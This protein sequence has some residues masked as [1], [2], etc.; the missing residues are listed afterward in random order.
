MR[1]RPLQALALLPAL[2]LAG[3][4]GAGTTV[5]GGNNAAATGGGHPVAFDPRDAPLGC[6][7]AKGIGADK[8]PRQPD[9]VVILPP[10]SG[11][12][13]TFASTPADAQSRQLADVEPGAEVIGP[14]LLTVGDLPD[15]ELAKIETCLQAQG[16]K[17]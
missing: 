4:G 2:I 3:C 12:S 8:D 1:S 11:A 10:A 16:S 15:A 13:I 7:H 14:S 17:Y 9:R 5:G 6:I